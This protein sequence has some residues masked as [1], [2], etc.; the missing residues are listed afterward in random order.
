MTTLHI[1]AAGSL[2]PVWPALM[3]EF[4]LNVETDFGPA[5]LLR[6]RIVAGVRCDLFASANL[7]HA[8][9]LFQ[10]GLALKT[11]RFAANVL[12][13]TVKRDRVTEQDNWLSLLA[14]PDLTLATSTPHSDPSGDYTWQLFANIEQHHSG[15]GQQIQAKARCLVGGTD[16]LTVPPGEL[17][18]SWLLTRNHADMFI[19]YASYAPRLTSFP[20]LQVLSIPA[21]YNVRAEYAWALCQP[22]ALVLADFLQSAAAQQILRQYGFLAVMD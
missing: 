3:A 17:A 22:Q 21:P 19:G 14:R 6:E 12:C 18:A 10:R 2:K 20:A 8:E 9:D 11:G 7:A 15:L 1:L 5:G 16:S 13:L 4:G